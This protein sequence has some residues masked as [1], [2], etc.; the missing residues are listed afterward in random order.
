M[1]AYAFEFALFTVEEEAF[2]GTYLDRPYAESR[3]VSVSGA[4]FGDYLC[5]SSV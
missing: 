3:G 2:A 5:S 4:S 1:V